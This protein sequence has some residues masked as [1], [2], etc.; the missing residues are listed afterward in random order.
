MTT[1]PAQR[2][3][4][5]VMVLAFHRWVDVG[6]EEELNNWGTPVAPPQVVFDPA[7]AFTGLHSELGE[8]ESDSDRS[9]DG[10]QSSSR[11]LAA[12]RQRQVDSIDALSGAFAKR[13]RVSDLPAGSLLRMPSSNETV[14]S[15]TEEVSHQ[16]ALISCTGS[17]SWCGRMSGLCDRGFPPF[18]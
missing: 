7:A 3:P 1:S 17:H 8:E 11:S 2:Q 13:Q 6:N 4:V 12:R 15:G 16:Q 5:L 18:R 10:W 9:G 14:V